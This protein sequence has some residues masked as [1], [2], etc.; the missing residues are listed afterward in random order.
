VY[1][2][3]TEARSSPINLFYSLILIDRS[4]SDRGRG[5]T[6]PRPGDDKLSEVH[7]HVHLH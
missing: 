5:V 4:I 1:Q 2:L 7:V 6:Y 3:V